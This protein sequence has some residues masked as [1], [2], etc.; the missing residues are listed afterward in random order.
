MEIKLS[1]HRRLDLA[2][3]F[4]HLLQSFL[5]LETNYISA[6]IER[7]NKFGLGRIGLQIYRLAS[8]GSRWGLNKQQ[9]NVFA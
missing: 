4:V 7:I 1:L 2:M 8:D 5:V 3:K 6:H 9:I